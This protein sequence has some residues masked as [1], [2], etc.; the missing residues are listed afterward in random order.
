MA[1]AN[2]HQ[3]KT[4]FGYRRHP[5]QDRSGQNPAEHPVVIVGAGPV[6]LSLAIDLAQRGQHVVLLDDADRIG[7]GSRA[8]CFSK[9]SLEYWDRLG[10]GDRMVDKGV[11]WSVG[12]IFHGESQLYQ[13]NLLPEDGH[14]RP[15]FINLQQYYAEAYLVDRISDLP[16]IDLR[17]RNKVTG[18]EQ[19]NDSVALTIETPEGAYRL[20]GQYVIACDGARSSLRQM[21]GAEFAG[22]VFED[23]FLIADV[24][25]T[26]EFPTERW[27]WFDPPF[28]AGRSALLH[29][30]PDDVWRIDL[31]LNRYADPVVEKKPE[32]VRPRIARMLG[33]DKF[34]FE[35]IS[36]Y[37]FQCRRMDRFIHGRVIFAGDS[38]HQVSP[39]GARGANSGLEDAENL[40]WK[41]D[42]VLRRTSPASLLESYHVERSMAADENIRESTRSTDFMA[43]NSHQE[44]RLRK[45]V[46]S[47]ARETEFGKRMVNGGRLSVPCSYDSPLSSPDADA[48]RGG[49]LPGR[50]MLD[51]PI[52]GGS[53]YLTDAFRK[54]GT[55]FTLLSFDHGA[56]T[57]APAGVKQIR[58]GE[59]GLADPNGIVAKRYDAEAGSAY[60]LRPDGYVAARFRHP[61][62]DGVAA[63]L[64][65]AQG[66]N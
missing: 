21:V 7:E 55:A 48:W 3:A 41:L 16:A 35:W 44:A 19:R 58:I 27:F 62:R 51:A 11:V 34:E 24:K 52:A 43:P 56:P 45:A 46:L 42:R 15:A 1:P 60:L 39:F 47:L 31:Q 30:Q 59:G 26:A 2:T 29:R 14:K 38:A 20:H 49:P 18:I 13:F 66:L 22:Q 65:R 37:K 12:R 10:V 53:S 25:M 8:I 5:D 54:D 50:S 64:S 17:W 23:Q 57:E 63:A 36:L 6:G 28:H 4:Q 33:H 40:S 9:R 61:T 32:N